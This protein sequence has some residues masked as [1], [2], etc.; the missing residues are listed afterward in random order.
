M[1]KTPTSGG[2]YVH[3]TINRKEKKELEKKFKFK[4]NPTATKIIYAVV[5]GILCVSAI[6][7]GIVAAA[8]KPDT[9]PNEPTDNLPPVIEPPKDDEP[10]PEEK[11]TSF[12]SPLVGTVV[13]EHDLT[14]PVF[15]ETLGAWRVHAG[16]DISCAEG[17]TVY[18]SA[19]GIVSALFTDPLYG[20]T[21]EISHKDG[22]KT[23]YGNLLAGSSP[24]RVGDSVASGDVIGT[25]GDSA[26]SEIAEEAHIH[27]E[28]LVGDKKMNPLDYIS[29][30]SQKASLGIK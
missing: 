25:V 27:F 19:D 18:A 24:F 10:V 5:V 1:N 29:K 17:A 23:R 15:S 21:V 6:V 12:V 8:S 3:Q 16:I 22:V 26:T 2:K 7:V 13:K 28:V 4:D 14:A 30:E 11:P 9:T 20:Y